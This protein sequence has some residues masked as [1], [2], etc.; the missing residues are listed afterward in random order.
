MLATLVAFAVRLLAILVLYRATWNNFSDH[1]LFGFEIGRIA[2]SIA[3]GHGFGNPLSIETGP[4]A[5]MTPV[6][7][8]LVASV[9]KVFGIYSKASALVLLLLNALFSAAICIPVYLIALRCFGAGTAMPALWIWALFPVSINYSAFVWETCLSALLL[10]CLFL[11]TL[12]LRRTPV[13]KR[14]WLAFG[15]AWGVAVMT[16]ASILSLFPFLAGWALSPLWRTRRT[17]VL[18]AALAVMGLG[19]VLLPWQERNSRVFHSFIPLRDTFWLEFWVG[20]DG[21]TQSVA[22]THAHPSINAEERDTYGQLGEIGYIQ[23]KKEQA[24]E[25]IAEHPHFVLWLTWRRFLYTWTGY[26]NRDP[27][28]LD[29]PT[30]IWLTSLTTLLMLIGLGHALRSAREVATPFCF[31]LAVYPL[32]FYVTHPAGRY[33]HVIDPEIVILAA[34][35]LAALFSQIRNASMTASAR[36][37]QPP[38]TD[39]G[40]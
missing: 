1:L 9:F 39:E 23:L 18:S 14:Y 10:A 6:Y 22:D 27:I 4:T 8:Y 2:R 7:P 11:W 31:V 33:R 35:G 30:K 13:T 5:W 37:L 26:W 20:N 19:V 24:L 21:Y 29:Q 15:A 12:H 3:E 32:V 40:G 38:A 36:R 16:N 34:L 25:V 28:N 17:W